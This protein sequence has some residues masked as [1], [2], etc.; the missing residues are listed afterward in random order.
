MIDRYNTPEMSYLFSA[1]STLRTWVEVETA[2]AKAQGAPKHVINELERSQA[3]TPVQVEHEES[4]TR[5]DVVA[6]LNVWRQGLTL[7]ASKWVHKG[8]TSS[9]LVDTANGVRLMEATSF[10]LEDLT[11]LRAALAA[12]AIGHRETIRVGRTHGQTAEVTTWGHR[13][14]E[15]ACAVNRALIRFNKLSAGWKVGKLSGPV[16]TH[17]RVTIGQELAAMTEVGLWSPDITSQIVMRDVY[18]DFVFCCAQAATAIEALALE[19]RLSSR[20]DTGEVAEGFGSGQ[21]GSSSMPHKRNPITS[22]KLCGLARLVRA[23]IEPIMAGIASHHERDLSHSS[24][25]RVALTD[26]ATLTHYMVRTAT[27][28]MINLQVNTQV[29]HERAVTSVEVL[30]ANIRERLIELNIEAN[31]AWT[32]VA[33]AM[34]HRPAS[35][36][37]LVDALELEYGRMRLNKDPEFKFVDLALEEIAINDDH[38]FDNVLSAWA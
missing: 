18:A 13:V 32:I 6:F 37:A 36:S 23:Q 4:K 35:R 11:E 20:T 12:H 30:S 25:E 33:K 26:A 22:E 10:I 15:F 24:V 27:A 2:A 21:K 34:E 17:A 8:M 29:M 9:D 14:A 31:R 28:L 16:G 5:H 3:P 38:I 1:E 7:E 19:I